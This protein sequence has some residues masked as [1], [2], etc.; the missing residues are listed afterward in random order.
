MIFREHAETS[1]RK[2]RSFFSAP[3]G[4]GVRTRTPPTP[5]PH[6]FSWHLE[7]RV[8]FFILTDR[9]FGCNWSIG[10]SLIFPS[11]AFMP[12]W[13]MS[14]CRRAQKGGPFRSIILPFRNHPSTTQI[15]KNTYLPTRSERGN[16]SPA[17][18]SVSRRCFIALLIHVSFVI[19]CVSVC[20]FRHIRIHVC[21]WACPLESAPDNANP[22]YFSFP[23]L[24]SIS[25]TPNAFLHF[26]A[27]PRRRA[28]PLPRRSNTH[29]HARTKGVPPYLIPSLNMWKQKQK[30]TLGN[31]Q[32]YLGHWQASPVVKWAEAVFGW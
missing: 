3:W 15:K 12:L 27:F 21:L 2:S 32:N 8:H 25:N 16:I 28:R 9:L 22:V 11:C 7:W 4:E 30:S 1:F 17:E 18:A 5:P 31:Y 10:A 24:L 23:C 13:A 20:I 26:K 6:S 19:P 29:K 14:R